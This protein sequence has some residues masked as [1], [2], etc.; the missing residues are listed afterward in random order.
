MFFLAQDT[1]AV[2][3][4]KQQMISGG[5]STQIFFL[6]KSNCSKPKTTHSQ[7]Q[8]N[9]LHWKWYSGKNIISKKK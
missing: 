7:L 5:R 4:F 6:S 8:V 2:V 3:C 1:W 9:I